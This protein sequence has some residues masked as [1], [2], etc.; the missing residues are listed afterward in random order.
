MAKRMLGG[1]GLEAPESLGV[2]AV[3]EVLRQDTGVETLGHAGP[4]F[5]SSGPRA[6]KLVGPEPSVA[7]HRS[8]HVN[9]LAVRIREL[10]QD[11]G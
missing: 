1:S 4:P 7:G 10:S 9:E 3:C 6:E 5:A 8:L 2:F 11:E